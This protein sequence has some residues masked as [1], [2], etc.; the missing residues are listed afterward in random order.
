MGGL[1]LLC[2]GCFVVGVVLGVVIGIFYR[3]HQLAKLIDEERKTLEKNL[4]DIIVSG[5]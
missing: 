5:L 4:N 1:I 3:D 2:V